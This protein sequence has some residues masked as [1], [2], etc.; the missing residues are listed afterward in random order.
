MLMSKEKWL[1]RIVLRQVQKG[2]AIGT[3][4]TELRKNKVKMKKIDEEQSDE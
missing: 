2:S 4:K 3:E 1:L